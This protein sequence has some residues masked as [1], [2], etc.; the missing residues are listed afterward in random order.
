MKAMDR[1]GTRI[2]SLLLMGCCLAVVVTGCQQRSSSGGG[3][4]RE[5]TEPSDRDGDGLLDADEALLGT[6][7]DLADSDGDGLNDAEEVD[8]GTS[9]LARDS[10]GDGLE[11]AQDPEPTVPIGEA[12]P[13]NANT[14]DDQ[15]G[16]DNEDAEPD[17]EPDRHIEE[18]EPNDSFA[19]ATAAGLGEPGFVTLSGGI[20]QNGDVDIFDLGALAAGD[21]LTVTVTETNGFFDPVAAL[22]DGSEAIVSHTDHLE[23]VDVVGGVLLD[24][25]VRH[26]SERYYLAITH[27]L[28]IFEPGD[29]RIEVMVERGGEAPQPAEQTVYLN[30]AGG[31]VNDPTLGEGELRPFDAAAIDATLEGQTSTIKTAIIMTLLADF[32]GY[33]LTL[34]ESDTDEPPAD[35]ACCTIYF[36]GFSAAGLSVSDWFDP[37][38][39]NPSDRAIIYTSSF[40]PDAFSETVDATQIGLA[41]GTRVSFELGQ[42]LGLRPVDAANAIM[43]ETTDPNILLDVRSFTTAPLTADVF[44]VGQQNA[45][46][47]LSEILGPND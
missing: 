45:A 25:V 40:T 18:T 6:N 44:P 12:P 14:Q 19:D 29:Y 8:L 30:F 28:V 36:G 26:E 47:L 16:N 41:I 46:L 35:D 7:P 5:A 38:N 9:P 2:W 10:D 31:T 20:G 33:G 22:F 4:G 32:E 42:M 13:D 34:I 27:D 15:E 24:E 37:Y 43:V 3:G 1:F 23:A 39:Q 17:V 21:H 11:D